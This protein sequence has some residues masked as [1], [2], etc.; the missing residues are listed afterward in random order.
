[1]HQKT[2]EIF[3]RAIEENKPTHLIEEKV[4]VDNTVL[5]IGEDEWPLQNR[6]VYIIA[7]G[8]ASAAMSATLQRKLNVVDEH[9]ITVAKASSDPSPNPFPFPEKISE[10]GRGTK[11]PPCDRVFRSEGGVG[12][13]RKG[14]K[15]NIIY[16]SHPYPDEKSEHAAD[17][18]LKFIKKI[19]KNPIVLFALSGGTSALVSKPAEGISI[20]EIAEINKLLLNSG[21]A[22][23]EINCVR[24]HLSDVKGGQLLNYFHPD[25]TLVD[26]VISDVPGDDLEH[27]GSGLTI[28][29]SSTF[30][31]AYHILVEFDLWEKMPKPARKHIKK[32]LAGEAS[33]TLKPGEDPI[34]EHTSFVIGSAKNF[35]KSMG[36][37]AKNMGFQP[38]V[39][40]SYYNTSIDNV[41]SE[42]MKNIPG[43]VD[44]PTAFIYYGESTVNI[45]G[46]GKGGRN[47][48]MALRAAVEIAG[49]KN[50][51]WLSAGTDGIDGPTDA[52]GAIVDGSTIQKAKE[53]GLDIDKFIKENDSYH[54]HEKMNTHLIIGPTGNNL[55]DVVLI[56]FSPRKH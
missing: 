50:I 47:Q 56:L 12:V 37:V 31:D 28:P 10:K 48:E 17:A 46:E 11:A 13:G 3:L 5:K 23:D 1:M 18:L 7:T 36:K 55:M 42:V 4:A 33:E 15:Q 8:K 45:T 49:M 6:P 19:P 54:F 44:K 21:A 9:V 38:K 25:I 41:I 53:K 52:A 51:A 14:Q 35:A 39:A 32:G 34:R 27:I 22:I 20:E 24:K 16:A 43:E 40:K 2:K 29:D 26:L 30:R